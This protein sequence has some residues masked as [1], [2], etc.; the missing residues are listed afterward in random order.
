MSDG[1]YSHP[2]LP[3]RHSY[4]L[5]IDRAGFVTA[6]SLV[7]RTL[8]YAVVRFGILLGYSVITIVWFLATFGIGGWL[9][10]HVTGWVGLGW[11]IAGLGVYGWMWQTI[12]RYALYLIQA[13][14]IAVLTEL[15]TR[16]SIGHGSEGMFAYG[17]RVVTERFGE[18]TI[19]FALDMLIRGVVHAFNRTLDWIASLLPIP[20]LQSVVGIVNAIVRAATTYI[21]ETIFS[22]NLAR[23]DENPWRSSKDGLI[24]YCQN[25]QEILKTAAWVVVLDKVLTVLVWFVMLAPAFALVWLLPSSSFGGFLKIAGLIIAALFASNVRQAFL[26]PIFLVMVMTKFHVVVRNQGINLEWDGRLSSVSSKFQ[27]IK[28]KA[29]EAVRPAATPPPIPG[30]HA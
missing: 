16:G 14:H 4:P 13:G 1:P 26:K 15:V 8:P 30:T 5:A 27:E 23:G 3:V 12:V 11:I 17:K 25:S 20:G 21:D 29:G 6:A 7:G 18:V 9:G 24:Y 28:D 19:L 2:S 10:A 22:Y